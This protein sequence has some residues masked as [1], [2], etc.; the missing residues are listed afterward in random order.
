MALLL[1]GLEVCL[2]VDLGLVSFRPVMLFTNFSGKYGGSTDDDE[3]DVMS[4]AC[5]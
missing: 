2:E 1:S 5:I 3:A 4:C